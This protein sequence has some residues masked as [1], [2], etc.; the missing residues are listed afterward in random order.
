MSVETNTPKS[1]EAAP[2]QPQQQ[3]VVVQQ[4]VTQRSL[5][6]LG[7]WLAFWMVVFSFV[8]LSYLIS[9]F[10]VIESNAGT[11]LGVTSL[12]F[13]P[14]MSIGLIASVVL[15]AMRKRLARIVTVSTLA[16]IAVFGII[17]ISIAASQAV[18]SSFAANAGG[19]VAII[20]M[21]GLIA[22]YFMLSERVKQTLIK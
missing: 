10:G 16:L 2:Q 6:G 5:N 21:L 17:N 22:L 3:P 12:I 15:I 4:I 11:A 13:M 8:A 7:G 9:F 20:I 1:P 14:V 18:Y 19:I